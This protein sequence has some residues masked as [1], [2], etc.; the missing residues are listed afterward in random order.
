MRCSRRII[1][2][3]SYNP[4]RC[5]RWVCVCLLLLLLFEVNAI[6]DNVH[7]ILRRKMQNNGGARACVRACWQKGARM[8]L[9]M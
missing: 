7:L 8:V 4:G 9:H 2:S 3:W 1:V 6:Y 5:S